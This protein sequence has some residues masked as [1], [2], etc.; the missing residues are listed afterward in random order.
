M[1]RILNND[2]KFNICAYNLVCIVQKFSGNVVM[3]VETDMQ[4]IIS[5][6]KTEVTD[7]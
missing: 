4:K 6:T 3:V 1:Y 7:L 5:Q 2:F